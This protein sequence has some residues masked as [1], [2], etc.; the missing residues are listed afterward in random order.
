MEI[1]ERFA[2]NSFRPGQ[3]ELAQKVYESCST[4]QILVAEAMS[5]F[6]KTAAVL[7]GALTAAEETGSRVVYTCR[8]KRQ[9]ARVSEEISR[10]QEKH[11]FKAASISSKFDYCL[12]RRS[13]QVTRESFGWYC[14]FN[15][16]NNLCSYFL[17]VPLAGEGFARVVNAAALNSPSQADLIR[18]SESIHVCPYEVARLAMAQA[19]VAVAPYHYV[20]DPRAAPVIFDR[21]TIERRRTILIV[22]EAHNLRDFLRGLKGTTLSLTEV[23]GAERE[24]KALYLDEAASSLDALRV[25]LEKEISRNSGWMLNKESVLAELRAQHGTP[26]LQNLAYELSSCSGAAWGAIAYDRRMPSLVLHVGEF[27]ARLSSEPQS[28]LVRWNETLGLIDPDPTKGLGTLLA[29]FAGSVLLSATVSPSNL[30]I[31]SLGLDS[32]STSSY[33]VQEES[34]V[35]VRTAIDLGVT[36]RYKLRTPEMYSRISERVVA[37]IDA[38]EGR[39][40][41]FLPSYS[42]LA[43]IAESVTARLSG[44][45]VVSE[46]PG[47]S[48]Q[49]AADVFDAFV[50]EAGSVMFGVQGGRFSE[51]EDFNRGAIDSVVVVGLGLPPPSPM[52]YAEYAC[53]KR[54]GERDSYM[55]LSRLPALRKAFQAAGR[56][57]RQ[58]GKRGLVFFLDS[59][60]NS[61]TVLELMPSWLRV[62]LTI[63]DF[64]PELIRQF[65]QD[66]WESG[67]QC[68]PPS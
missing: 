68:A 11:Q 45:K 65:A 39:V 41:V 22:D 42:V 61:E 57:V 67:T 27:L 63:G 56:H 13:R 31:K 43:P 48:W 62:D 26:W 21:N 37:V 17:N 36:T 34:Q 19:A 58:P 5:G 47:L 4:G 38:T 18:D 28:I 8:T 7:T 23:E 6:G 59:R 32:S 46:R 16:S 12:L 44:R 55:M 29:E 14:W 51:G 15:V 52:L 40:G 2:Y 66:F 9:M 25:A 1:T 64:R 3:R 35:R 20:F 10:L 60:F 50:S 30:F 24:A 53:L 54:A 49:D 33:S